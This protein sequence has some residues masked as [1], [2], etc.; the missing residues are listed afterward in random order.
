MLKKKKNVFLNGY[1]YCSF[2]VC[3]IKKRKKS[4]HVLN[5][6]L[7]NI[8]HFI[9]YFLIISPGITFVISDNLL[10]IMPVTFNVNIQLCKCM[11][12]CKKLDRCNFAVNLIMVGSLNSSHA[13][14]KMKLSLIMCTKDNLYAIMCKLIEERA[15]VRNSLIFHSFQVLS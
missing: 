10:V 11:Y 2:F 1:F 9:Q 6:L 14:E 15:H 5:V 12:M 13:E 8:G 7:L 3:Q 4:L